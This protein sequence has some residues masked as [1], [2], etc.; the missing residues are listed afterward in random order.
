[1]LRRGLTIVLALLAFGTA[2]AGV[3]PDDRADVL[4]HLYDGGGVQIDGPSVLVRKKVGKSVS[5]VGNYYVDM[6]SSASIDVVTTGDAHAEISDDAAGSTDV[7]PTDRGQPTETSGSDAAADDGAA[8]DEHAQM[9]QARYQ[10]ESESLRITTHA[11]ET[12]AKTKLRN[13]VRRK[14]LDLSRANELPDNL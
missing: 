13:R 2:H 4:Y 5:L 1:M 11:N 12:N 10:L 7:P 3:L 14:S 6:I 9:L 8:I